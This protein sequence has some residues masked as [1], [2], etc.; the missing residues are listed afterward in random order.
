MSNV[1]P[2]EA[3]WVGFLVKTGNGITNLH[4][5][6]SAN[7]TA[8]VDLTD[9][10]ISL[11]AGTTGNTVPTPRLK[12]KF[13]TSIDGTTSASFSA[14]FYRDDETDL[15]WTTLARGVKGYFLVS[16]FGGKG[17][18]NKPVA[19]DKV[20]VWPVSITARTKGALTSNT[21]QT[22]TVTASVPQEPDED[23]VVAA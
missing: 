7:I 21:V 6:T 13:E 22:F 23:A 2:N 9:Y 16:P 8:A 19:L 20:E 15:A 12:R 14:D 1:I 11:N 3:T 5:P 18:A 4:A 17:A 10:L